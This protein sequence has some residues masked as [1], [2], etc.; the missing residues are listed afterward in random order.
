VSGLDD[1]WERKE[2][3]LNMYEYGIDNVRGWDY[4]M[5]EHTPAQKKEI[6]RHIACMNDFCK[7]CGGG[8]HFMSVCRATHYVPW[9]GGGLIE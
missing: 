7:R 3:L 2:T 5:K 8:S 1:D 6:I 4:V 9:A